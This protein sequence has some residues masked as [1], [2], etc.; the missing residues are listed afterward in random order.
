MTG[1]NVWAAAGL[2]SAIADAALA[3]R[4]DLVAA[5]QAVDT[6]FE[7]SLDAAVNSAVATRGHI[8]PVLDSTT[9]QDWGNYNI[10]YPVAVLPLTSP[11]VTSTVAYAQAHLVQ[12]LPTYDNGK[13]LHDYL[14]FP[15][16]QNELASGDTSDAVAGF[17]A[18]LVHTTSTDQGWEESIAPW[19]P[20]SSTVNLSP[21]GT[22]SADYIA[23]L[24]NM[25]VADTP[26]G[27]NLLSGASPAWLAP[28]QHITI[29]NAPTD[30]GTIS[31]KERST[32]TGESLTWTS[33]SAPG[34]SLVWTIPAWA[35]GISVHGG[36]LSGHIVSLAGNSGTATAS[37]TGQRPKQSYASTAAALNASYRAHGQPAPLVPASR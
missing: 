18:E 1:D 25:L 3:R 13:S 23:L 28:G 4:P 12:G 34:T 9:G 2:R 17:Y 35:H 32:A 36:T 31:F 20:R 6:R 5:W 33:D 29:T 14:G 26:T 10:A 22:F 21:H 30:H 11:A 8:P 37:F 19:G 24:R 15:I 16:F 7:A 27:A